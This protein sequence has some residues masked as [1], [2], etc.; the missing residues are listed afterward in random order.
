MTNPTLVKGGLAEDLE[1]LAQDARVFVSMPCVSGITPRVLMGRGQIESTSNLERR[2]GVFQ[3]DE[4][5][6]PVTDHGSL[7]GDAVFEGIL[8]IGGSIFQWREHLRRLFKSAERLKINVPYSE[9]D[10][11]RHVV[12][13]LLQTKASDNADAYIRLVVTR[14]VGDLGIHPSKCAGGTVYAI[15]SKLRLYAESLYEKG[16]SLSVSQRVRRTSADILDPQIKSCNY[17]NNIAALLDTIH[18]KPDET[19]ML[20]RDGYIAEA[21]TDNFFL[22]TRLPGWE[23]NPSKV[24]VTTP[25]AAYCL[26]GITRKLVL[27]HARQSGFQIDESGRMLPE[28]IGGSDQEIFLTGT[29]AGLI[30]VV[31]LAG[32]TVGDG[33][34]GPITRQLRSLLTAD[35][36]DPT[37]GL[38][39]Y[40]SEDGIRDYLERDV[41]G[42]EEPE[43]RT[44]ASGYPDL[45]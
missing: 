19:L 7:Y 5:G 8:V 39:I 35:F 14:G 40:A 20:T 29:A 33:H 38:S 25:A 28:E 17:L 12:Q 45:I 11:T 43:D 23:Q 34:P 3:I 16:I 9:L 2:S 27:A 6:L 10:L 22:I 21:T 18:E 44:I 36:A 42:T 37:M 13:T 31:S 1:R 41:T 15:V 30:P 26:N 24:I 32:R 4:I